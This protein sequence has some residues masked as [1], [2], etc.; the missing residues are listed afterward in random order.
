MEHRNIKQFPEP[1]FYFKTVWRRKVFKIDAT[2][3]RRYIL[4]G[5]DNLVNVLCGEHDRE[6]IDIGKLLKDHCLPFHNRKRCFGSDI[7]ETQD[8]RAVRYDGNRITLYSIAIGMLFILKN[9]HAHAC[10]TRRIDLGEVA[11]VS[12]WQ[13]V[14]DLNLSTFMSKEGAVRDPNDFDAC[15]R[16]DRFYN[17]FFVFLVLGVYGNVTNNFTLLHTHNVH[18]A[19]VAPRARNGR[20]NPCEH[21]N[22]VLYLHSDADAIAGTATVVGT[23]YVSHK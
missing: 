5:L 14:F 20:C 13:L 1:S 7:A 9:I 8:S 22:L 10:Y 18:G 6:G 3:G 17:C 12:H 2:E 15:H 11:P 16:F 4:H 23:A 21:S 19:Q